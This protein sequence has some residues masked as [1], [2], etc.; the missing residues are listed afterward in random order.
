[1][2]DEVPTPRNLSHTLPIGL[3]ELSEAGHLTGL[4][5]RGAW[6]VFGGQAG[7]EG[8]GAV[9]GYLARKHNWGAAICNFMTN[10]G[11][12]WMG[13][14][15]E[16]VMVQQ[17]PVALV[18]PTVRRLLIG[19]G[20]GITLETLMAEIEKYDKDYN[21]AARLKIHP[22]ALIIEQ[23]HRDREA[24]SLKDQIGST[25]K[26]CGAAAADKVM[27]VAKLARD[28]PELREFLGDTAEMANEL[29]NGGEGVLVEGAQGFD[30]DINYGIEYPFCTSRQCTPMQILADSGID[31]RMVGRV[32]AVVRTYP[33]RV[34]GNSGPFGAPELDWDEISR[35]A[36]RPVLEKTTVTQKVRR[37][38]EIDYARLE[39]MSKICRPTDVALTF[40]DYVNPEIEGATFD[41][42]KGRGLPRQLV[43]MIHKIE[44]AIKRRTA[45]PRV[46]LIKTGPRNGEIIDK[47]GP[48][49]ELE[50]FVEATA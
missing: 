31:G 11:H 27:R 4:N 6:V 13:D 23:E 20:A 37:V 8:K 22:R 14:S 47:I 15:G 46:R 3:N 36:G 38:F 42:L 17:L 10:A 41:D 33:I 25:A 39:I 49:D 5:P 43:E 29:L 34:G 32:I 30:L 19:P 18:S 40:A 2:Y 44:K 24:A 48:G 9:A 12:T 16:H 21:V 35:R 26:G 1:M 45:A 7:S 50:K 28:V